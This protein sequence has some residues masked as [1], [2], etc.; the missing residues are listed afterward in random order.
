MEF[1]KIAELFPL[2]S[3]EEYASLKEDIKLNGLLQPIW[4]YEDRIIDG[5]NRH[6]VCVELGLKPNYRT[7]D[8]KG[9]LVSF[10]VSINLKRRHLDPGQKAFIA[11]DIEKFL[12]EE[13]KE[14]QREAT[15][16]GNKTRHLDDSPVNQNFDELATNDVNLF[17]SN[18]V[19]ETESQAPANLIPKPIQR[20]ASEQAAKI[21]GTNRQYVSDAK[22]IQDKAPDVA[23]AVK[24]GTIKIYEAKKVASLPEEQRKTVIEKVQSGEKVDR[25]VYETKRNDK[26]NKSDW[27]QAELD[28]KA[29]VERGNTVVAH[30]N[31]DVHLVSWAESNNKYVR[32]D[33]FSDWGNPFLLPQDG[34]RSTVID[35]YKQYLEWRPSLLK[36][37]GELKGKVLG[38]WCYPEDCHGDVLVEKTNEG[39]KESGI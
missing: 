39:D 26:V 17:K 29:K 9:S 37:L 16:R 14:R 10:V 23:E 32:I 34:D 8:G 4:L 15:I 13:A 6:N 1:H 11:L 28:R 7:W 24:S 12:A 25:A 21:V 5:R 22:F 31:N 33:R 27:S 3:T 19:V 30:Q 38:C 35:H 2:M 18:D 36:R 20:Q